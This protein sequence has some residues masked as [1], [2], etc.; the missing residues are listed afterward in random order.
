MLGTSS[1]QHHPLPQGEAMPQTDVH[2]EKDKIAATGVHSIQKKPKTVSTNKKNESKLA[3]HVSQ[4]LMSGSSSDMM[5]GSLAVPDT[6]ARGLAD[7]RGA[8][9]VVVVRD[10]ADGESVAVAVACGNGDV[11][12]AIDDGGSGVVAAP[13]ALRSRSAT[14]EG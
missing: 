11:A 1:S 5:I 9:D 7:D 2:Y 4:V 13:K 3:V 14:S 12:V 10:A 6:R 8:G